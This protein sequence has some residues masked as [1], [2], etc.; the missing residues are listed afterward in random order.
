MNFSRIA[1]KYFSLPPVEEAIFQIDRKVSPDSYN[2]IYTDMDDT[3]LLWNYY[4]PNQT[5]LDFLTESKK[6]GK[7]INIVTRTHVPLNYLSLFDIDVSLFDNI[8]TAEGPKAQYMQPDSIFIDDKQE[9]RDTVH[10]TLGIPVFNPASHLFRR[11]TSYPTV[12]SAD[13]ALVARCFNR[14][15]RRNYNE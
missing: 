10:A 6:R 1:K 8:I 13:R 5:L 2:R 14:R 4:M 11:V 15:N 12:E 3:L 9:E 7:E